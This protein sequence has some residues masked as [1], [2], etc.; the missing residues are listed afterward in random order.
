MKVFKRFSAFTLAI[1]LSMVFT[2]T[3]AAVPGFSLTIDGETVNLDDATIVSNGRT[4]VPLRFLFEHLGGDYIA[5]N[6]VA[7]TVTLENDGR[8][9]VIIID[10]DDI[11]A[12][13]FNDRTFVEAAFL[14][15][16][17]DVTT[18]VDTVS[19]AVHVANNAR[20]DRIICLMENAVGNQTIVAESVTMVILSAVA[21]DFVDGI[22]MVMESIVK[23]DMSVPFSHQRVHMFML[24]EEMVIEVFDDGEFIYMILGDVVFKMPSMRTMGNMSALLPTAGFE[25]DRAHYAGLRLTEGADAI[26]I[27]GNVMILDQYVSD[28]LNLMGDLGALLPDSDEF[29]MEMSILIG[30]NMRLDGELELIT[31]MTTRMD[32]SMDVEVEGESASIR[33]VLSTNITDIEFGAEFDTVIPADIVANAIAIPLF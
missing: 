4:L 1:V 32:I 28:I 16:L 30:I 10:G 13:I 9:A 8:E 23:E 17:L 11:Y 31:Y 20:L 24:G 29:D 19:R 33:M 2:I 3:V 12:V 22:G 6:E 27:T 18:H 26:T 21:D 25:I 5:W 7:R 14:E 15:S